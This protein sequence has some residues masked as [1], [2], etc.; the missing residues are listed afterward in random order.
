[1]RWWG[2]P[3][4]RFLVCSQ[5]PPHI[6]CNGG[7]AFLFAFCWIRNWWYTMSHT[8]APSYMRPHQ[9]YQPNPVILSSILHPTYDR[10]QTPCTFTDRYHT[11]EECAASNFSMELTKWKLCMS[12]YS[13]NTTILSHKVVHRLC[14]NI[15]VFWPYVLIHNF[16]LVNYTTI[17]GMTHLKKFSTEES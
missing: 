2:S 9:Y 13:Q 1:V 10:T 12:T 11:L 7:R 14:D 15:V 8:A 4:R 5:S 17:T 16:H 6:W 3:R